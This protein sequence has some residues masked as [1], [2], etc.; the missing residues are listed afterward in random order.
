M[1]NKTL[2]FASNNKHKVEEILA[3]IGD[4]YQVIT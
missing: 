4:Q 2:I 3:V 1:N